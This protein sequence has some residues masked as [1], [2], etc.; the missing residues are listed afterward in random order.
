MTAPFQSASVLTL[1]NAAQ[2]SSL[3]ARIAPQWLAW[4]TG[5]PAPNQNPARASI[6]GWYHS[7]SHP[8][9]TASAKSTRGP[10]ATLD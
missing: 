1:H 9:R 10:I 5:I 6:F 2:P 3:S 8:E 7:S 4:Q